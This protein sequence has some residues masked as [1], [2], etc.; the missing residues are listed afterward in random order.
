MPPASD[1]PP[2]DAALRDDPAPA[3]SARWDE[4][5]ERLETTFTFAG[6]VE[7][8]DFMVRCVPAIEALDHH[9]DWS[10]SHRRVHVVLTTHSTGGVTDLDRRLAAVM[11][12]VH[13][14]SAE[15]RPPA[16]GA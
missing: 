5:P 14:A 1:P 2:V 12:R 3:P 11:D 10:N 8:L 7:A 6:F 9:P 16:A 13:E 4:T 15:A